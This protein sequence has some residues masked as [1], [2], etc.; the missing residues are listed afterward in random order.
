VGKGTV[1]K[2]QDVHLFADYDYTSLDIDSAVS[3]I[4]LPRRV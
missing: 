3:A 2:K 4:G 1:E